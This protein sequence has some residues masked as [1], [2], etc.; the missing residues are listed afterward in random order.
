MQ[1]LA[2][3]HIFFS[4]QHWIS[5]QKILKF[6]ILQKNFSVL[7]YFWTF[8]LWNLL[9]EK[10][11][12]EMEVSISEAHQ[13]T[14][15]NVSQTINYTIDMFFSGVEYVSFQA[16]P[17]DRNKNHKWKLKVLSFN[18]RTVNPETKKGTIHRELIA[19]VFPLQGY[20]IFS[21]VSNSVMFFF[22]PITALYSLSS[23]KNVSYNTSFKGTGWNCAKKPGLKKSLAIADMLNRNLTSIVIVAPTKL[24]KP[25]TKDHHHKLHWP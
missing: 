10:Q 19:L 24:I 4:F 22:L 17:T 5:I 9:Q 6:S 21:K 14:I 3:K 8:F 18:S 2:K 13:V 7:Y 25:N 11:L 20:A 12:E 15:P 23:I 16:D 1:K